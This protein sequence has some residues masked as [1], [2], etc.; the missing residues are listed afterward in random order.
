MNWSNLATAAEILS[1]VAV[2]ATLVYLAIQTRQIAQA[3]QANSRHMTA[4]LDIQLLLH[5][6]DNA[7]T[8]TH[9]QDPELT[10]EQKVF[11][12]GWLGAFLRARE[13]DWLNYKAGV[14][15]H[16]T[17]QS[18]RGGL[19]IVMSVPN[20]RRYWTNFRA[21]LDPNFAT[22]VDEIIDE[23]EPVST[24]PAMDPFD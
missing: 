7:S 19:V 22:T 15:D 12:D 10:D 1:S 21:T 16:S 14:L 5:Q 2:L 3:T 8:F 9:V 17:W 6:A 18:Y 11:F 4:S 23:T 13:L 20:L 24:H